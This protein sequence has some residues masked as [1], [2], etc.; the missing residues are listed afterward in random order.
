MATQFFFIESAPMKTVLSM[1]LTSVAADNTTSAIN[2][3]SNL[4]NNFIFVALSLSL[5]LYVLVALPCVRCF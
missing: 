2:K 3:M 4:A 5:V 1:L